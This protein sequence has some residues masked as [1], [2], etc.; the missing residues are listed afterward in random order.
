[1]VP[2]LLQTPDYARTLIRLA[3]PAEP[4]SEIT[5]RVEMRTR[6]QILLTRKKPTNFDVIL[7]ES[8]LRSAVGSRRIMDT[9]LRHLADAGTRTNISVRVLP[10][11]AGVPLGDLTGPFTILD[12]P[13]PK[14]GVTAE[15][16]VVYAEGYA[17]AMYFEDPDVVARY[18]QTHIALGQVALSEQDSRQLLR[19]IAREYA[20]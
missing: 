1:M 10:F 18:R 9:Q 13:Q 8:A 4:D 5:R 7:G 15:P 3:H 12:F 19:D 6:R 20:E 17:G 14:R 11:R 2:G 16:P